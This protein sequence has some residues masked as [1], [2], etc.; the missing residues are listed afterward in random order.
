[1]RANDVGAQGVRERRSL[2]ILVVEDSETDTLLLTK[3]L[4]RG[5]FEV[6]HQQVFS[7]AEMHAALEKG[8][9]DLI[10][11][12]HSMPQFSSLEALELVKQQGLDIP[13]IIVS[14]HID[15]ET[16]VAAMQAGAHDY[17]MKERLA[18]LVPAVERELREAAVI[19]DLRRVHEDLEIRVGKR[20]QDLQA[21]NQKL[22]NV[23]AERKRL[24]TELLEIA[25]NER[26]KI[27]L[28]LHDDL[29]QKLTGLSLMI[30][31]VEHKLA[32][33]RHPCVA[34]TRKV[35]ALIEDIITHTHNLAHDFSA[36]STK[37]GDLPSVLKELAENVKRMFDVSC[38]FS[39]R[40]A[41]PPFPDDATMQLYKICQ[42]AI[43]NAIKHGKAEHVWISLARLEHE[44][45]LNVKNDGLPFSEPAAAK[46]RMGLRIMNYRA[47]TIGATLDIK[48]SG[49]NGAIVT[50]LLPLRNGAR[51]GA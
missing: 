23:I 42:E 18:R 10:L 28:D 50:C 39:A 2:R 11:V 41:I 46:N 4:E 31:G 14:G 9:W 36:L 49:K 45:V 7:E 32:I 16:A 24:E 26:R 6:T 13:F 12:D 20:T 1:M 43:S 22:Q 15:E 8:E 35:H 34:E 17:I 5:G 27:G 33:D 3:V 21:A 40:G 25:E 19:K 44:L 51:P 48:P 38:S 37:G 47:N 29:G 30:K